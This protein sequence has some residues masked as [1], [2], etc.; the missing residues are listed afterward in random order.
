MN[1]KPI[2]LLGYYNQPQGTTGA[3]GAAPDGQNH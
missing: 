1:Y 2:I 3:T